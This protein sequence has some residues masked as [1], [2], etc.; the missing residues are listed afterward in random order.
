[1]DPI[2]YRLYPTL[3][4]LFDRYQKGYVNEDDFIDRINRIPIPQTESQFK[5]TSFEEAVIKG[6]NEELYDAEILRK[7]RSLLP[8]PMTK[9][10]VYCEYQLND[11]VLYGYV[12][13]IGKMLAVDI[14]TTSKYVPGRFAKSHQN[15]Y[16]PALKS[17]GIRTLRYVITDFQDV[18]QEDYDQTIDFSFQ[19]AQ[20]KSFCEFLEENRKR[21]TDKKIFNLK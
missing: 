5:G 19:E 10:Q 15:F 12:D 3:L 2:N 4:N 17:R 11:V 13:V 6:T 20:I 18:Y 14:K 7:V 16:L 1:M 9:T 8:R 21:I